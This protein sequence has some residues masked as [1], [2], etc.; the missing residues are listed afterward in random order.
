MKNFRILGAVLFLLIL[1]AANVDA[2]TRVA[3]TGG[4]EFAQTEG[5]NYSMWPGGST[6]GF[7]AGLAAIIPTSGAFEF[8]FHGTYSRMGRASSYHGPVSIPAWSN[9][10]I[11]TARVVSGNQLGLTALGRVNLPRMANGLRTYVAAGPALSWEVSCHVK[12]TVYESPYHWDTTGTTTSSCRGRDRLDFGL[13][14]AL[15]LEYRSAGDVGVTLG[16]VYTHGIRNL[17]KALYQGRG[18]SATSRAVTIRAGL[19]Y[20]IG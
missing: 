15:G 10:T 7:S 2:Q 18:E 1:S 8:E 17:T 20:R 5:H 4:V 16:T 3:F 19:V 13:A 14:G 6:S 11:R 12:S 9:D